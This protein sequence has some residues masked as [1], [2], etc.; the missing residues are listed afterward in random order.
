M[1]SM[2]KRIR[3]LPSDLQKEVEDFVD[4]IIEKRKN[5]QKTAPQLLWAGA[6]EDLGE[7]MSSTEL[8]HKI[9]TWHIG[10]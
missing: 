5:R 8:Q 6:L 2:E 9:S 7:K 4:F 10:E 1:E 3:S